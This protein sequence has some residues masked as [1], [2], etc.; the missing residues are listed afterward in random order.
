MLDSG[1]QDCG[2]G[3]AI[4]SYPAATSARSGDRRLLAEAL[5]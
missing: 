1:R 2:A 4:T 5:M 3:Q